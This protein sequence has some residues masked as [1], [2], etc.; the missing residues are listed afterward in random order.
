MKRRDRMLKDFDDDI[1][2]HVELET[3]TN[4]ARGM[5]PDDARRAA[6]LKFGNPTRVKEEV[7]EVWSML[8]LE[9][10]LQDVRFGLRI[11]RRNPGFAIITVLTLGLGIGATTA[12][13]SVVYAMLL[14]PL[15]YPDSNELYNVVQAQPRQSLNSTG[16]SYP[17]F[18]E[19]RRR[20]QVF[21]GLAGSQ[22]HQL[23]LTG[24][25]E[26]VLVNAS[27]VTGGFFDVFA[28]HPI[29]GR[30]FSAEDGE[31]GAAPIVILGETLWRNRFGGDPGIVGTSIELDK[32]SFTVVGIVPASFRFPALTEAEQ[33]WIPLPQDPLF[34]SW[35]ERR[36]GHWLQVTGR[37]KP[38]VSQTQLEQDMQVISAT[39]ERDFPADNNGWVARVKPLQQMI[40]GSVKP[41]LLVLLAAV[42]AVLL[43]ACANVAN[44]LLARATSRASEIA[45]RNSLGAGRSRVVRQL[46]SESAVLGLLG[47]VF[48]IVLAYVGIHELIYLLPAGL[49]QV[50]AIH[51]DPLVLVFAIFLSLLSSFV[52]GLAPAFITARSSLE[53]NLREGGRTGDS[54]SRRRARSILAAGEIALAMVLL[55]A[56]G[57]LIRS[58]AK[59][60]SVS[61]GFEPTHIV[62]A[63]IDLPRF[64]YS[65]PEQWANFA[66]GLLKNIQS[67]PGMQNSAIAIPLPTVQPNVNLGFDIVGQPAQPGAAPRLANYVSATP[68][69]LRVMGIPL[70]AGRFFDEHDTM[71]S[72]PV[73]VIS[74]A[75]ARRY[76]SDRN[77]I[78]EHLTFGFP[79]S[80]GVAREIVGVIGDVRD[81][82]LA[83]EPGPMMYVPYAQAPF[84][85]AVVLVNSTLATDAVAAALRRDVQHIDKDLPITDIATVPHLLDDSVAQPRFR[86]QLLSLFALMAVILAAIGIFGV[87]A[88]SVSARTNEIGLRMALGA[89]RGEILRQ[90]LRETVLLAWT[91]LA[92]G[93]PCAL[94]TSRLL[95]HMLFDVSAN[96]PF[97]MTAV[98]FF[99]TMIAMAAGY[100]PARRA[101]RVDPMVALRYQ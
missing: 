75:L 55:A 59:L 71:N 34:G 4:I 52:F 12:I 2:E 40:V 32:R 1:R 42:G 21:A 56:A 13:F 30:L 58:F 82:G 14:K 9:Q 49:P 60:T 50:N 72:P 41:I 100:I 86:T 67:E 88:Y 54:S 78:G 19:L 39:L 65:K 68:G 85:G 63:E 5:S 27:V 15:P 11:L 84:W 17:N 77:P 70:Q 8:W 18:T 94:A 99:L 97:T 87:I 53:T 61:P 80:P 93:V 79:P 62:T 6:I 44:L 101:A 3:E 28:I 74:A 66:D 89:S 95:G 64:Q 81:T 38:G 31:H 45:I 36:Q 7:R 51:V 48:G 29:L 35:L 24:R 23:T 47:G 46:L 57:L 10:L 22:R 69:Y 98:A 33:L 92:V 16:W 91:G 37:L 76:F 96:D 26:P 43:I 20:Q 73:T 83:Q 90:V 25:G